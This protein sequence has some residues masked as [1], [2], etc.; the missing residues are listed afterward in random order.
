MLFLISTAP[1][2]FNNATNPVL[3]TLVGITAGDISFARSNPVSGNTDHPAVL[4]L[5]FGS[6]AFSAGDS[7]TFSADTDFFVSDPAPGSV[8]ANGGA[9]FSAT[10]EGSGSQSAAF[11]LDGGDSVA[12]ITSAS[13]VVPTPTAATLGL[14]GM[15]TLGLRRRRAV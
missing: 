14:L 8:F 11:V 13:A 7:I 6:G 9:V 5:N 3:N 12:E 2:S 4:T 15:A 10:F 1:L